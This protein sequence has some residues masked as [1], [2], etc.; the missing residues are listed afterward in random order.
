MLFAL[1]SFVATATDGAVFALIIAALGNAPPLVTL[2]ALIGA[3]CGGV[4]HFSL[5]R[6]Y[7]FPDGGGPV[8]LAIGRY[9]ATSGITGGLHTL[10]VTLLAALS[11]APGVAW[12]ASKALVYVAWSY[13][14]ARYFVFAPG[15]KS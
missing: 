3:I 4:M 10:A 15:E 7:V 5:C 8:A 9:A 6:R 14:A 11:V 12:F 1:T 2:A 13:P